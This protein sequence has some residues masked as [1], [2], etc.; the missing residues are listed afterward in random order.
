[1]TPGFEVK[2]EIAHVLILVRREEFD[3]RT[4]AGRL[5]R[6]VGSSMIPSEP[7]TIVSAEQIACGGT[8]VHA[9]ANFEPLKKNRRK[10]NP[11]IK[12]SADV[13]DL[14]VLRQRGR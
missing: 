7:R 1:M 2:K 10:V 14:K 6:C 12:L 4:T 9:I 5:A 8:I 13:S 3:V 11:T